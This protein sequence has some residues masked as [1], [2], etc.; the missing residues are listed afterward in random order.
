MLFS[1]FNNMVVYHI[2]KPTDILFNIL[3][4]GCCSEYLVTAAFVQ[5][6]DNLLNSFNGGMC[7]DPG[8]SLWCSLDKGKYGDKYLD[9]P[10]G[11]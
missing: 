2:R 10:Q 5:E 7:V 6:V 8:E 1:N 3:S 9:L 11:Q 4:G